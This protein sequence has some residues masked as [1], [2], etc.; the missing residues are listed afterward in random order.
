M[1]S[2]VIEMRTQNI[3]YWH[4]F[5]VS[6]KRLPQGNTKKREAL[7]LS[8]AIPTAHAYTHVQLPRC[9]VAWKYD[10]RPLTSSNRTLPSYV[11]Q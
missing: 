5:V 10:Y 3:K 7:P 8:L 4:S 2:T 1:L 9:T 6:G 11:R